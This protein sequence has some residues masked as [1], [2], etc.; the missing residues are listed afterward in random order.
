MAWQIGTNE[1]YFEIDQ[2]KPNVDEL[3]NFFGSYGW[4]VNAV[5]ALCGN[6]QRE[7]TLNPALIEHDGTGH[8]LVQWTPPENLYDV[9][10]V[11]YGGHGDWED[12]VK[13]CNVIYAEYEESTGL[14][15]RG[16]EPQWYKRDKWQYTW[17]EWAHS[18]DYVGDL[19]LAFCWEYERPRADAAAEDKRIAYSEYW[20]TFLAG[21]PPI[22]PTKSMP[23]WLWIKRII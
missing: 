10:D 2:M 1:Q 12:P 20:Y 15:D 7:S 22:R 4:T 6:M 16:I 9:L 23:W 21:K 19:A 5:A 14:A 11:L 8:G 17:D 13:Q 18:Y 3:W